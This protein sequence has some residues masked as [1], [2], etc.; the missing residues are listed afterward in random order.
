MAT[1]TAMP[2]AEALRAA[3]RPFAA[4]IWRMV[5]AQHVASTMKLTDSAAEQ[6]LLEILVE[7]GKPPRPLATLGLDYL[8]ASPFRYPPYPAGSRFRGATD[9]G[10]FYG[11]QTVRTACAELGY[12]R[13]RFLMDS[14]ALTQLGPVPHTAFRSRVDTAA[15]IDLRDAPFAERSGEW[16]APR[17]YAATQALARSAREADVA[18]ILSQSVR[19]PLPAWCATLLTPKAFAATRP[20]PVTQSWW[21]TVTRSEA[22]WR[23]DAQTEVFDTAPWQRLA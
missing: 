3:A 20:D 6:D 23:R 22:I 1:A 5:E 15:A 16:T 11:A 18:V 21:L 14:P 8:L 13:W 10:V 2:D 19:D 7:Q 12:W 4:A 9:P 17:D